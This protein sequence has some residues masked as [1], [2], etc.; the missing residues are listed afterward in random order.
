MK[1]NYKKSADNTLENNYS[2]K[3]E[4]HSKSYKCKSY[5]SV[6]YKD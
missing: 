1:I 5:K 2:T 6:S 4:K 3:N